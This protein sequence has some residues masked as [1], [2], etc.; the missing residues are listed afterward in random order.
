VSIG[1]NW[2]Y[3]S[4]LGG[5]GTFTL[6]A[7]N[8]M[9]TDVPLQIAFDNLQVTS[10]SIPEPATIALLGLGILSLRRRK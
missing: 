2:S 8:I 6:T 3:S 7:W 9:G 10:D 1:G 5:D 4:G